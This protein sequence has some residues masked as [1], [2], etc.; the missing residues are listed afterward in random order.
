MSQLGRSVIHFN[1]VAVLGKLRIAENRDRKFLVLENHRLPIDRLQ[2]G[3]VTQSLR[4]C[5]Y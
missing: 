3:K 2:L 5:S 1:L 4:D